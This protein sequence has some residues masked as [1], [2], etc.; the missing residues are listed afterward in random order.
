MFSHQV[1]KFIAIVLLAAAAA[2]AH[3]QEGAA[4]LKIGVG[5][6][7]IGMGNA[8]T[9]MADDADSMFWNPAGMAQMKQ[10]QM[11]ASRA[12]MFLGDT[13]DS[14]S[15]GVPLGTV[16]RTETRRTGNTQV[17]GLARH[18]RGVLGI[19][20]TRLAQTPQQG[21][22]ADRSRTEDFDAGDMALS[23]GYARPLSKQLHFGFAVK[24]IDS[25]IADSK[26]STY[27]IDMGAVAFIGAARKW[28]LGGSVRN[29]GRGLQFGNQR[30]EL[31][32]S[33][34]G[35]VAVK[36]FRGFMIAS[37]I[38]YR[39]HS[40]KFIFNLGTEYAVLS[41]LQLR[42][43]FQRSQGEVGAAESPLG[44]LGGGLGFKLGRF[45]LDYSLTPFGELG[46]VQR[47]SLSTKF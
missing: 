36:A 20:I 38:Q 18:N 4:F 29:L 19:G 9:A 7:A 24:R 8:Y 13:Y 42:A 25:R 27:A 33:F 28:R 44:A 5:A 6:R 21:R 34:A 15:L 23:I 12:M 10:T 46:S 39:P 41:T 35:G 22:A 2:P 30:S 16:T 14:L 1:G 31:P 32:L 37:E 40:N 17:S 11:G 26:A 3:A 43:G 47:I 45:N